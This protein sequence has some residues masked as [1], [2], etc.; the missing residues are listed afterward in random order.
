MSVPIHERNPPPVA[1]DGIQGE[2]FDHLGFIELIARWVKPEIYVEYGVECGRVIDAVSSHC[3]RA[4]GIGSE[5]YNPTKSNIE[6]NQCSISEFK[7]FLL[8][9][10]IKIDMVFINEH[11][12]FMSVLTDFQNIFPNVIPNGMIFLR[13]TYPTCPE[14]TNDDACGDCWKLPFAIKD[15]YGD[16]CE[17]LTLPICPGLTMVRK[18]H[19]LDWETWSRS[20]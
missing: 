5:P 2:V 10:D 15:M 17:V 9:S 19:N 6:Y 13:N 1:V 11:T 16:Q 3:K 12:T 14:L 8:D 18:T 7:A 4:I 20:K